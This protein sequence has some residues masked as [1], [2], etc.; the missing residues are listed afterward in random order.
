MVRIRPALVAPIACALSFV[1]PVTLTATSARAQAPPPIATVIGSSGGQMLGKTT[2]IVGDVD[3]DGCA[4]Y[5]IG[6]PYASPN[7]IAAAGSALLYSGRTGA[8]IHR[9]DGTSP[10]EQRA[11]VATLGDVNRDSIPDYA[12]AAPLLFNHMGSIWVMSGA[13]DA[14]LYEVIGPSP[15]SKFGLI[16]AGI[17][18]ADG[19][20]IPDFAVG[21]PYVDRGTV[22][23]LSG[24]DGSVIR[25]IQGQFSGQYFGFS[26]AAIGDLDGDGLSDVVIGAPS[27][28]DASQP[29]SVQVYSPRRGQRIIGVVSNQLQDGMGYMVAGVGDMDGDGKPDWAASA[30]WRDESGLTD[31]GAAWVYSGATGQELYRVEGT[32]DVDH[33]GASLAGVGLLDND[34]TPDFAV[35]SAD[36]HGPLGATGAAIVYSGKTGDP[37]LTAGPDPAIPTEGSFLAGGGDV[38]GDGNDDV[39]I[40]ASQYSYASP[41]GNYGYVGRVD[42]FGYIARRTLAHVDLVP[43]TCPNV[44][45]TDPNA[46]VTVV[47]LG[48]MGFDPGQIVP[49]SVRLN[50]IPP[51]SFDPAL[52]DAEGTTAGWSTS[53]CE[54]HDTG[55]DGHPDR[56]FRFR[57]GDLDPVLEPRGVYGVIVNL[58]GTM[59]DGARMMAVACIPPEHALPYVAPNPAR[60]SSGSGVFVEVPSDG[61]RVTITVHDVRGRLIRKLVDSPMT[62][63][64]H[65]IAWDCRREDG[66]PAA[67]GIYFVRTVVGATERSSRVVLVP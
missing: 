40:S 65:R 52:Q 46:L 24:A 57:R 41:G 53:V 36:A 67:G 38:D 13:T 43:G 22:Y 2:A 59:Q 14:K 42:V 45:P 55:P 34:A 47:V 33:W 1:A 30:P 20:S 61:T 63:G 8:L 62:G 9:V 50:G 39:M 17:G 60:R 15:E 58:T 66:S 11:W 10:G 48:D 18:D 35:G 37:I 25:Q 26:V 3:R 4:D 29:G 54:C 6:V 19:D 5:L 12:V 31:N 64:P 7:G 27:L 56:A 28:G 44:L 51:V 16:M 23:V 49:T 32:A 21:S